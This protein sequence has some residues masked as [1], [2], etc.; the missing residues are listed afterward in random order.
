MVGCL[1]ELD[2]NQ[3]MSAAGDHCCYMDRTV[4]RLGT[5]PGRRLPFV[6]YAVH[7]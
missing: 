6:L 7:P 4:N 5:S 3:W 2:R 1:R